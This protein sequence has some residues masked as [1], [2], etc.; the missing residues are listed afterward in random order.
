[1]QDDENGFYSRSVLDQIGSIISMSVLDQIGSIIMQVK[2]NKT[3]KA[4]AI[5]ALLAVG[6]VAGS[7]INAESAKAQVVAA[8]SQSRVSGALT[9]VL[10]NGVTN[11][12]ASEV[13]FP[14]ESIASDGTVTLNVTYTPPG[15]DL[16]QFVI[17]DATMTAGN[18]AYV[19]STVEAATARAIDSAAGLVQYGDIIGIVKSWQSGGS[20]ALD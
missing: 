3:L 19:A 12:F 7:F 10:S 2:F 4:T 18:T 1:M 17:T 16:S 8:D 11:S 13:V 15:A 20:A 14:Q 6:A 5:T 9:S